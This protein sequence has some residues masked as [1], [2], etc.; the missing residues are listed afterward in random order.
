MNMQTTAKSIPPSILA[1]A[2]ALQTTA[3]YISS[4]AIV[5]ENQIDTIRGYMRDP[6]FA[7]S[8]LADVGDWREMMTIISLLKSQADI[9]SDVSADLDSAMVAR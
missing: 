9:V 1:R 5:V 4:L 6:A 3:E 8:S 2:A 7:G